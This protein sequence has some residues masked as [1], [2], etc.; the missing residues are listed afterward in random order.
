MEEDPPGSG[1]R[2]GPPRSGGGRG[3]PEVV[4]EEDPPEVVAEED[5]PPRSGSGRGPP[6]QGKG[7]TRPAENYCWVSGRYALE[8][9][10]S[11]SG[12]SF[13]KELKESKYCLNLLSKL[14]S[15]KQYHKYILQKFTKLR[16]KF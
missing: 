2:R 16:Q 6:P 3:P 13:W 1:G 7:Q 15:L 9:R 11:S 12:L 14:I 10:L 5:P 8:K 4:V